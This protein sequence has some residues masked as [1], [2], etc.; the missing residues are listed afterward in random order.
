MGTFMLNRW[1]FLLQQIDLHR[2]AAQCKTQHP[3]ATSIAY[4]GVQLKQ[5]GDEAPLSLQK[6]WAWFLEDLLILGIY[7][8]LISLRLISI[9]DVEFTFH[10]F[11]WRT[12]FLFCFSN[13]SC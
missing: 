2:I 10:S 9:G 1:K 11:T 5:H 3:I 7:R 8:A 6:S 4:L 12:T 13:V